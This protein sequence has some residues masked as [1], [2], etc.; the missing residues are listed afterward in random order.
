VEAQDADMEAVNEK[1]DDLTIRQAVFNR[2]VYSNSRYSHLSDE[3]INEV[4]T[5]LSIRRELYYKYDTKLE[6]LSVAGNGSI[7]GL[8]E[9]IQENY[10]SGWKYFYPDLQKA[11]AKGGSSEQSLQQLPIK[12]VS[13]IF[14]RVNWHSP[15]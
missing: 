10:K 5:L 2:M 4:Y 1:L 15:F 3:R 12:M 14:I 9:G 13:C 6:D 8:P 11:L 7:L